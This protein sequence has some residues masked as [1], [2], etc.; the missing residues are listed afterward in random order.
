MIYKSSTNRVNRL[1]WNPF[2]VFRQSFVGDFPADFSLGTHS[3]HIQFPLNCRLLP[4][5]NIHC[6]RTAEL[7]MNSKSVHRSYKQTQI[8]F[9]Q[10]EFESNQYD[11]LSPP[12]VR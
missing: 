5:V 11:N 1:K 3:I 6:L 8:I 9:I 7:M 4:A 10:R 2:E 12:R